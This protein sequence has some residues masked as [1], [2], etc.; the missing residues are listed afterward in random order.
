MLI[1]FGKLGISFT[2][3]IEE[4]VDDKGSD[5]Y[6]LVPMVPFTKRHAI[7]A[8][9][10]TKERSQ[11]TIVANISQIGKNILITTKRIGTIQTTR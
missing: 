4:I 6:I 10:L 11:D 5:P 7:L 8:A 3:G 2:T 9:K 1:C